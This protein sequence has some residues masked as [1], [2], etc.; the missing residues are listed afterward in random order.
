[1][2]LFRVYRGLVLGDNDP[3]PLSGGGLRVPFQIA[4]IVAGINTASELNFPVFS[5]G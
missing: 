2:A 3:F 5:V 4:G 1:M